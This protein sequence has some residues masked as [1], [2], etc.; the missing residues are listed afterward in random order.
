M[1]LHDSLDMFE[2]TASDGFHDR[3]RNEAAW[4]SL[5]PGAM[6]LYLA[7]QDAINQECQCVSERPLRWVAALKSH[8]AF[9]SLPDVPIATRV[10]TFFEARMISANVVD[11]GIAAHRLHLFVVTTG[12]VVSRGQ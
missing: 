3:R 2:T 12:D 1:A 11:E 7:S 4:R 8:S 10:P 5:L 6:P 9:A